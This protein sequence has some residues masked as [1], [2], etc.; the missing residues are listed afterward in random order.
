MWKRG[1]N[2][3]W[4]ENKLS[5]YWAIKCDILLLVLLVHQELENCLHWWVVDGS[6][7][8]AARNWP[9]K[10]LLVE[11]SWWINFRLKNRSSLKNRLCLYSTYEIRNIRGSMS[12]LSLLIKNYTRVGFMH[13]IWK[14]WS[15][16]TQHIFLTFLK[17][18]I[19]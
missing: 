2:F 17:K 12:F 1:L 8:F 11:N 5:I 4:G 19:N 6:I 14:M 3:L 13:R 9:G 15:V 16:F 7:G 18:W 10:V